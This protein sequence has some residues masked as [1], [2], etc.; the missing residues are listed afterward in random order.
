MI[1][2]YEFTCCICGTKIKG[3]W[4]NNPFPVVNVGEC[5]NKCNYAVV[6]PARI[7]QFK[8]QKL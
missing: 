3:E 6:I 8:S 5:C 4:G 1:V 2:D 7:K